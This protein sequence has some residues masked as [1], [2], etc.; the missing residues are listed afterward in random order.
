[1]NTL[2]QQIIVNIIKL[3]MNLP[4]DQVWIR[5][6]NVVIPGDNKLYVVVGM[7]GSIPMSNSVYME[8]RGIDPDFEQWQITQVTQRESVQI[9]I[10]SRS[11]DALTR[12]WE[13]VAAMQSF[14]SQQ[15]QELNNFKIFRAP[16]NFIDGSYA[17]GSSQLN[18]Y[19]ITIPCMVWYRKERLLE[20]PLGDYFDTFTT[21]AND[22]QSIETDTPIAEFEINSG[23]IVP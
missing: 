20:T 15:Q 14:Y 12:N 2:L 22:E 17:E 9:D 8:Q 7:A 18:R 1:M 5:N 10:I 16:L 13:I 21:E 23:G 6:Q 3:E 4:N 11:N 19:I